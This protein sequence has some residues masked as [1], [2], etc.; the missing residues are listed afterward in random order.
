MSWKLGQKVTAAAQITEQDFNGAPLW[1]HAE[2]GDV[3]EVVCL[4]YDPEW[5]D[6]RFS[7]SGT[8]TVCH[9]SELA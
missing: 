9:A 3:G 1:I 7:E 4:T 2:A 5:V 8:V 6:V